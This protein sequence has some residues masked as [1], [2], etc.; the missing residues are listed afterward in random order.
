MLSRHTVFTSVVVGFLVLV[1]FGGLK[2]VDMVIMAR[3]P[4]QAV[5]VVEHDQAQLTMNTLDVYPYDG[6]HTQSDFIIEAARG[7]LWA[8]DHGFFID[9]DLDNPPPKQKDELRLILIGGSGAAGW[10]AQN[11]Y[12]MVYHRLERRFNETEPC[13]PGTWLRVINLAMGGTHSYQNYIALNR[14]AHPLDPDMIISYSG[15][16]DLYVSLSSGRDVDYGYGSL[17]GFVEMSRHANSPI[18][19]KAVAAS[20]RG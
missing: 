5:A 3:T 17:G 20:T 15:S 2:L 10:G 18:W 9:F 16:N 4:A 12:N 14:W 13:G 11:N 7:A 19:L 8:G 6:A 1:F